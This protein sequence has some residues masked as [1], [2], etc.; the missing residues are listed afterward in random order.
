MKTQYVYV[1]CDAD[2]VVNNEF[3]H[4]LRLYKIVDEAYILVDQGLADLIPGWEKKYDAT[5][6]IENP[7]PTLD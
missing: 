2:G 1:P 3:R 7:Y 5:I 6:Q 4:Y